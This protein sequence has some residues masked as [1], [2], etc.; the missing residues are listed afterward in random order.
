M[1]LVSSLIRT[2]TYTTFTVSF[3]DRVLPQDDELIVS[4]EHVQVL[5]S[6]QV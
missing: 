4:D 6:A 3:K 5:H 1:C 2:V